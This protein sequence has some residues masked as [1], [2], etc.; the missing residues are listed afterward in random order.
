MNNNPG[1]ASAGEEEFARGD[2]FRRDDD[3][4]DDWMPSR[5]DDNFKVSLGLGDSC[6]RQRARSEERRIDS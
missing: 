6:A 4:N 2:E 3:Q 1:G 5:T